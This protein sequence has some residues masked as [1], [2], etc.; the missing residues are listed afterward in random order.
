[1]DWKFQMILTLSGLWLKYFFTLAT[2]ILVTTVFAPKDGQVQDYQ[3]YTRFRDQFLGAFNALNAAANAVYVT[4]L[5]YVNVIIMI[6]SQEVPQRATS[7]FIA[8]ISVSLFTTVILMALTVGRIW[9]LAR[10]ARVVMGQKAVG[11]YYTVCAMMSQVLCTAFSASSLSWCYSRMGH[12][13]APSSCK[14]WASHRR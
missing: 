12:I 7:L 13:L 8:S 5:G 1:M 2:T 11:T 9:S 3:A 6:L 14:L 10:A 4:S